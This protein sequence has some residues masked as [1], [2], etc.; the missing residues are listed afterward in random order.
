MT[1][2]ER[3][4]GPSLAEEF[5]R[6][7]ELSLG[8]LFI[9][10]G[11]IIP[12][13]VHA[14]GG[15]RIGPVLLPMYL[16]VLVCAMLVS[17]AIAAG[18]GLLTPLLSSGL[19]GMPPVLP[20]LPVMVVELVSMS[21]IASLLRRRLGLHPLAATVAALVSGRVVLG[22]TV[23]LAVN[24][25]PSGLLASIPEAMRH[26]L[27]YVLAATATAV[28]GLILQLVAVPALVIAVERRSL[29]RAGDP[30]GR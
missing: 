28:P 21:V 11:V 4:Q 3:E 30:G 20:T 13:A 15:G 7:R 12:M 2:S 25:L 18:V 23:A 29:A 16:P 22:L 17:P 1:T 27:P 24:L 26:P 10:L 6:A 9:A 19:T 5:A 8:G 14:V